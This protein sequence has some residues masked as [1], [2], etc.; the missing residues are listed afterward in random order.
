MQINKAGWE[1][2]WPDSR[3][4]LSAPTGKEILIMWSGGHRELGSNPQT[5]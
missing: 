1:G 2:A 4:G 5:R 3:L